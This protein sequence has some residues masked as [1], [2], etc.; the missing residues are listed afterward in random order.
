MPQTV[1]HIPF[2]APNRIITK[3]Q[4]STYTPNLKNFKAFE[5]IFFRHLDWQHIWLISLNHPILY[6][7]KTKLNNHFVSS[8]FSQAQLLLYVIPKTAKNFFPT[9]RNLLSAI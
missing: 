8:S 5:N 2:S 6:G 3:N 1:Q 7:V 4:F 9:V